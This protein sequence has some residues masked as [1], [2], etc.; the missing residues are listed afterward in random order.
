MWRRKNE[1]IPK[2]GI[3]VTVF[4]VNPAFFLLVFFYP[5]A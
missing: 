1:I 2:L 3:K 4:A 5:Y